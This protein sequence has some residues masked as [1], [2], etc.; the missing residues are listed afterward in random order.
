MGKMY[1]SSPRVENINLCDFLMVFLC[2]STL[3]QYI[4]RHYRLNSKFSQPLFPLEVGQD[5]TTSGLI[6]AVL[7]LA[8]AMKSKFFK[9]SI[10]GVKNFKIV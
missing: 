4:I 8:G 10:F 6:A 1:D 3:F 7:P 5:V 9:I 2:I